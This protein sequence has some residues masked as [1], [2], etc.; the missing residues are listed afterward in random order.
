M[1]LCDFYVDF[2][3]KI[4]Q[5]RKSKTNEGKN[6]LHISKF[7]NKFFC[8]HF[9]LIQERSTLFNRSSGTNVDE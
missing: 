9:F 8:C 3:N 2:Y 6:Y 5:K 7:E 4:K 1:R